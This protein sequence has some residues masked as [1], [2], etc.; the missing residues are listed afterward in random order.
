MGDRET[1]VAETS[2]VTDY[3]SAAFTST[4]HGD[5]GANVVPD[6]SVFTAEGSANFTAS[7]VTAD[8]AYT[9]A[10][11]SNLVHG[12]TYGV[13]ANSAVQESHVN[14]TYETKPVVG[15]SSA[16]VDNVAA[17]ENA[18]MLSSHDTGYNSTVNGNIGGEAG[19]I[20]SGENGNAVDT[21]GGLAAE[22]QFVDGSGMSSLTCL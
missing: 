21:M 10:T 3:A 16:S 8:V 14:T 7:A 22:Q 11:A 6:S 13:D 4:G 17:T 2:T 18:S 20:V 12:N 19:S 9:V 5:T 15:M 1:V